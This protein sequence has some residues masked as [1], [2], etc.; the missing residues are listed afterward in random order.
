[1]CTIHVKIKKWKMHTTCSRNKSWVSFLRIRLE[2]SSLLKN[3]LH[4]VPVSPVW[5]GRLWPGSMSA[6][7]E[8]PWTVRAQPFLGR[9]LRPWPSPGRFYPLF[10]RRQR[11]GLWTPGP[12]LGAMGLKCASWGRGSGMES[13]VG[14][15]GMRLPSACIDSEHTDIQ[16]VILKMLTH[17]LSI[18][19]LVLEVE[20]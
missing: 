19:C 17:H 18:P 13:L 3:W 15:P 5:L 10:V 14:A 1:M 6:T 4:T 7:T 11:S 16:I 2:L 20:I 9:G 8:V 12:S